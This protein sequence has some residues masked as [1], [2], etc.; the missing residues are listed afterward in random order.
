VDHLEFVIVDKFDRFQALASDE[1]DV[2]SSSTTHTMERHLVEEG[3][4]FDFTVPYLYNGLQFAGVFEFVDCLNN[5]NETGGDSSC[6]D[7]KVCTL[8]G[9]THMDIMSKKFPTVPTIS[10]ENIH[11]SFVTGSCNVIAGEQFQIAESIVRNLGY[12]GDYDLGL[13]VLSKEPIALATRS[14]DVEWSDFVNWILQS[15]IAAEDANIS[16]ETAALIKETAAFGEGSPYSLAF[17]NAVQAV[18][19]Y[20]D[21]YERNLETILA[22]PAVDLI[23]KGITGQLY[24]LPFGDLDV[25][26]ESPEISNT[27]VLIRNRGFLKCVISTRVIFANLNEETK[28]WESTYRYPPPIR[29]PRMCISHF[30][31]NTFLSFCKNRIRCGLL[32][33]A[34]GG[35]LQWYYRYGRIRG[36]VRIRQIYCF[37][38]SR[39]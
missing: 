39:S 30:C 7:L 19:S 18:G 31:H 26:P 12:S 24:A 23:N 34:I 25:T 17:R 4:G 11:S 10:T 32:Q 37:G 20:A 16:Q 14:D 33:S 5:Y 6:D 38:Q 2:L 9:T 3:Q 28:A 8:D 21:L 36:F 27:L 35:P 15:L 29:R 1:F 13:E 22:R